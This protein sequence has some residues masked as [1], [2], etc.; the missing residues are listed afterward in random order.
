MAI[1]FNT[2][3]DPGDMRV[4]RHWPNPVADQGREVCTLSVSTDLRQSGG[5]W[6]HLLASGALPSL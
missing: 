4:R 5:L 6:G 2:D 1:T 3:D